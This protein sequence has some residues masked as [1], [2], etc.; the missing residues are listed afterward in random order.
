[1]KAYKLKLKGITW[2]KYQVNTL[3]TLLH[4]QSSESRLKFSDLTMPLT[5]L[6]TRKTLK[7]DELFTG[8]NL[9]FSC[10]RY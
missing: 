6:K 7:V 1:M 4:L 2:W 3:K 10:D 8:E 5:S 9:E